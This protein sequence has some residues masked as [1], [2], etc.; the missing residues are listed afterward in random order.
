MLGKYFVFTRFYYKG[1]SNLY[2]S[3][4]ALYSDITV[5]AGLLA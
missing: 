1:L 4:H 3:F 2:L 5:L